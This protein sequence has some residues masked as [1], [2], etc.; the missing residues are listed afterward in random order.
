M[1]S[2]VQEEVPVEEAPPPP[3]EP[4]PTEPY[5]VETTANVNALKEKMEEMG[6]NP[7]K[8]DVWYKCSNLPCLQSHKV[9]GI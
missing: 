6:G 4:Q 2:V 1:A 8:V 3:I 5:Q 7:I 9:E